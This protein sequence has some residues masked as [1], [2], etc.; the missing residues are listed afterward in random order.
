MNNP[1]IIVIGMH[2]SGTTLV[3][4]ILQKSGIFIGNKLDINRESTYF[5]KINKWL[6]SIAGASWD[7]PDSFDLILNNEV[8]LTDL[9]ER[10]K[11]SFSQFYVSEFLGIQSMLRKRSLYS[12]SIPWGWKDPRNT[13]TLPVHLRHFPSA[14][15]IHVFR[16]GADVAQS[17]KIREDRILAT[18]EN[19]KMLKL[20]Q[21]ISISI[22]VIRGGI[23]SSITCQDRQRAFD[24]WEKYMTKA[25]E[26]E[27]NYSKQCLSVRYE[28]LLENP[29]DMLDNILVFTG[30]NVSKTEKTNILSSINKNRAFAYRNDP[31]L[32]QFA[33]KNKSILEK[34]GY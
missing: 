23:L 20:K 32:K 10:M 34:F 22:P 5:Q 7:N 4:R 30:T 2:R 9:I 28:N 1:P 29:A 15:I 26:Y 18:G 24:L 11:Q 27:V 33:D 21:L 16:H 14:K 8:L 25:A 31:A 17:L 3:A 6:L 12:M 19:Q 13:F